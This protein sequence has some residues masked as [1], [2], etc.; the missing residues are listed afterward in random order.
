MLC[1]M[2]TIIGVLLLLIIS[3]VGYPSQQ[4][5]PRIGDEF[6]RNLQLAEELFQNGRRLE[7]EQRFLTALE[8]AL[9]DKEISWET[10]PV[11]LG[12]I[13]SVFSRYGKIT[14]PGSQDG[15]ITLFLELDTR[16]VEDPSPAFSLAL[17]LSLVDKLRQ[18]TERSSVDLVV[19]G[20]MFP[21]AEPFGLLAW[22]EDNRGAL[23]DQGMYLQI[24]ESPEEI[25]IEFHQ[26]GKGFP[27]GVIASFN[28]LQRPGIGMT[29]DGTSLLLGPFNTQREGY[30]S[31]FLVEGIPLVSLVGRGKAETDTGDELAGLIVEA[32][33]R[34]NPG[35]QAGKHVLILSQKPMVVLS[36]QFLLIALLISA[37]LYL[38]LAY[39]ERHR[40]LQ[41]L[42]AFGRTFLR[43]LALVLTVLLSSLLSWAATV[44]LESLLRG[45]AWWLAEPALGLGLELLIGILLF[46][47]LYQSGFKTLLPKLPKAYGLLCHLAA[48]LTSLALLALDLVFAPWA[49]ILIIASFP[50]RNHRIRFMVLLRLLA[51]LLLYALVLVT[52]NGN[53]TGKALLSGFRDSIL[54]ASL[55]LGLLTL[56]PLSFVLAM[57]HTR[58]L[59]IRPNKSKRRYLK[60]ASMA[61][62]GLVILVYGT[63]LVL[64][65]RSKPLIAV[66]YTE[67][68]QGNQASIDVRS[69]TNLAG[70]V[71]DMPG[72]SIRFGQVDQ[73]TSNVPPLPLELSARVQQRTFLSRKVVT[74]SFS[75][76][77]QA[78]SMHARLKSDQSIEIVSA[79][80]PWQY[81]SEQEV[82]FLLGPYP[83]GSFDLILELPREST[84]D[85]YLDWTALDQD[86][87]GIQ[88]PANMEILVEKRFHRLLGAIDRP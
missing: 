67:N 3:A 2:R 40:L 14:L 35:E 32:L 48:G 15:T 4:E 19:L 47:V 69:T 28:E 36:E 34:L 43:M 5:K 72:S 57:V 20:G 39:L 81:L 66:I 51:I 9:K 42:V 16:P 6:S 58:N 85:I 8:Q 54:I 86:G 70:T 59:N 29:H 17:V 38:L 45:S 10:N 27:A 50:P 60:T 41:G 23:P 63:S 65:P 87:L 24:P 77:P 61:G 13:F 52:F 80:K 46:M 62:L 22:I 7:R 82:I 53:G 25:L 33:G 49:I 56:I 1:P 31:P 64:L 37:S 73:Y 44:G 84:G 30:T 12:K 11:E 55:G 78:Q 75:Q 88:S 21:N 83:P 68:G 76:V 74:I 26:F 79:S 18:N 71:L